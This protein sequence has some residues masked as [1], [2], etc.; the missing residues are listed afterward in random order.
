MKCADFVKI[1]SGVFNIGGRKLSLKTQFNPQNIKSGIRHQAQANAGCLRQLTQVRRSKT[2]T[3]EYHQIKHPIGLAGVEERLK[4][5]M[6]RI[7][8]GT[9]CFLPLCC[10]CAP[11][12]E[13]F[14]RW[15]HLTS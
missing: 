1:Y 5:V 3:G 2:A 10:T 14:S 9:A 15:R 7:Q 4:S 8:S 12:P 6:L 11:S 13:K